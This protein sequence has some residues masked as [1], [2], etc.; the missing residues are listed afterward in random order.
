M[1]VCVFQRRVYERLHMIG[2]MIYPYEIA[3]ILYGVL[4]GGKCVVKEAYVVPGATSQH[5]LYVFLQLHKTN[6]IGVWHTHPASVGCSL[7]PSRVDIEAVSKLSSLLGLLRILLCISCITSSGEPQMAC[8][9][10]SDEGY[11]GVKI[12]LV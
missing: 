11:D 4:G 3:A 6:A 1:T 10:V 9:I 2:R 5:S 12:E 7:Q 8:Y